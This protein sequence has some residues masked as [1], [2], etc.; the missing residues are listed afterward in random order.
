MSSEI[1]IP[2]EEVREGYSLPDL[3]FGYVIDVEESPELSYGRHSASFAD[4]MIMITFHDA[5]GNENYLI[6]QKDYDVL[7]NPIPR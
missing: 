5:N 7:V 4:G 1:V 3:D 6:V 2:A